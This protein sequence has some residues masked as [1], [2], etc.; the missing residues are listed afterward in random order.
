MARIET[1]FLF[2]LDGTL[3]DSVYQHVIAWKIKYDPHKSVT[4]FLPR[5]SGHY[6]PITYRNLGGLGGEPFFVQTQPVSP[7]L[8]AVLSQ[9]IVPRHL[10]QAPR[11]DAQALG[12][13]PLP[14]RFTRLG[15]DPL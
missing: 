1:A 12:A 15:L 13:D 11:P 7:G 14:P 8:I 3:V 9:N 4:R 10:A 5:Q 2:D 6:W